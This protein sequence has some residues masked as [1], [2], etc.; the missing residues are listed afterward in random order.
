MVGPKSVFRRAQ[1]ISLFAEVI[2][3]AFQEVKHARRLGDVKPP[4]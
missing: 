2:F 3:Y 1:R 4:V